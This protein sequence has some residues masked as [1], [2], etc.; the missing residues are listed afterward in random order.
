MDVSAD[1]TLTGPR[2]NALALNPRDPLWLSLLIPP[3]PAKK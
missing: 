1:A 2:I 3:S